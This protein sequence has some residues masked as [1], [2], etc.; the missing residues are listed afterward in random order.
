MSELLPDVYSRHGE[1]A[2]TINHST[3][4]SPISR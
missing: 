1:T 2:W 4:A 3:P